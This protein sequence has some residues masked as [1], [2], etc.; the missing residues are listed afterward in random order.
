MAALEVI[1][2]RSD[3]DL[4]RMS[5]LVAT[6]SM[7]Q[8]IHNARSDQQHLDYTPVQVSQDPLAGENNPT[9]LFH[10][11]S[12]SSSERTQKKTGAEAPVSAS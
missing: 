4:S 7:P 6:H 8:F 11:L 12:P 1:Q 5:P 2:Y 3:Q 9:R 10:H